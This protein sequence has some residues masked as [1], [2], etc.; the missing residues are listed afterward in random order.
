MQ[1]WLSSNRTVLSP[2]RQSMGS[3]TA[4]NPR[5]LQASLFILVVGLFQKHHLKYQE[6]IVADQ[7]V[8]QIRMLYFSSNGQECATWV[9]SAFDAK[10]SSLLLKVQMLE[11][12]PQWSAH[13]PCHRCWEVDV[14]YIYSFSDHTHTHLPLLLD[15]SNTILRSHLS[16]YTIFIIHFLKHI[17][18][19]SLKNKRTVTL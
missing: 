12:L 6:N 2:D 1:M 11:Y 13:S 18:V 19:Q 7:S 8:Q 14:V 5:D 3:S 17:L 4:K 10:E 9:L 15:L 16:I